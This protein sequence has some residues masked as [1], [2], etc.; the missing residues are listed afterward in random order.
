MTSGP[1]GS[2]DLRIFVLHR[3]CTLQAAEKARSVVQTRDE[4]SVLDRGRSESLSCVVRRASCV[5][6][7]ASCVVHQML[8]VCRQ[9]DVGQ[10]P[11]LISATPWVCDKCRLRLPKRQHSDGTM[12]SREKYRYFPSSTVSSPLSGW[13]RL[14]SVACWSGLTSRH[15]CL[16]LPFAFSRLCS[17]QQSV[18]QPAVNVHAPTLRLDSPTNR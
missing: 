1:E 2:T 17:S 8:F 4:Q 11:A 15:I 3:C 18:S 14:E 13:T 9:T 5:V 10:L 12:N 6:R 16:A 7:R